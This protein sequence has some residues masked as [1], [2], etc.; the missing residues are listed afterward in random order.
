MPVTKITV[1]HSSYGNL[2]LARQ[3]LPMARQSPASSVSLA[4]LSKR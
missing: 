2:T 4:D 3:T 1:T